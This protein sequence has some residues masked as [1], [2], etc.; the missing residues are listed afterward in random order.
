MSHRERVIRA[1]DD[2]DGV[3]GAGL[4]SDGNRSQVA[5]LDRLLCGVARDSRSDDELAE[6]FWSIL[7]PGRPLLYASLADSN[8]EHQLVQAGGLRMLAERPA[9]IVVLI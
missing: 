7:A 3:Q 6:V 5:V 1:K 8:I 2:L 4:T 9:V